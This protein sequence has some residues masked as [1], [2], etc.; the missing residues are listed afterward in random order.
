MQSTV[1]VHGC[2]PL[3]LSVAGPQQMFYSGAQAALELGVVL[4]Q[5]VE[6]A[7]INACQHIQSKIVNCEDR[8]DSNMLIFEIVKTKRTT[9]C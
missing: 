5:S 2:I 4:H 3:P 9:A 7:V 1:V 8:Q 6:P